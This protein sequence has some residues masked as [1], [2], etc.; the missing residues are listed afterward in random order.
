ME[1]LLENT[2]YSKQ[3]GNMPVVTVP[4]AYEIHVSLFFLSN[5]ISPPQV[6][7][8]VTENSVD[9]KDSFRFS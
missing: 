5:P 1:L 6:F 8:G 7:S 4:L 3:Q 9:N 2:L